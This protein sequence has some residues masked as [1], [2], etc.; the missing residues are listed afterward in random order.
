MVTGNVVTDLSF[1]SENRRMKH[2]FTGLI[3]TIAA[4]SVI[5]QTTKKVLFIGNSYISTN[6]LPG[7][8]SSMAVADGNSLSFD[9]NTPG[10]S[11]LSQHAVSTT[12]LNKIDANAWDFVVLQEQSQRPSFPDGQVQVDVYPYAEI[13]VDS[14]YSNNSCSVPLFYATWG[15]QN[16]DQQ[17]EG[18]NT[19]EKMNTRLFNAYTYMTD[20]ANGML[21]P[22]GIGF[23]HVKQDENAVVNF[24]DLYVADGSH[25]SMKGSYLAACV[26]NN[27]IFNTFSSGNGFS[28]TG[29]TSNEVSYLQQ[30]ADHVVYTNDSVRVDFRPLSE[31]TFT[32]NTTGAEITCSPSIVNGVFES[33]DF[34]DGQQST[35]QNATHIYSTTG[36]YEVS[37]MTSTVCYS[38]TVKEQVV[39][40]TLG[41]TEYDQSI[42]TVYPN[43]SKDGSISVELPVDENYSVYSVGGKE[44]Y[45]GRAGKLEL[46]EG[47]YFMYFRNEIRKVIVL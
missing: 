46:P 8:I 38:D 14:I 37:M 11:T 12:T 23:A 17:W 30:V 28:P 15:R 19:F 5:G 29:L 47:V 27:L 33:W 42:F 40:T 13:L 35:Q 18:I 3:L 31:N 32:V 4:A 44:V 26:F 2:I 20:Q 6:N 25:P 39:I 22:V 9:S 34:G 1:V 43:P 36:T 45:K 7:I 21:S 24:N 41:T 10:G 16:G